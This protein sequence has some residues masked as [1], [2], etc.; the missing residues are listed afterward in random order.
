M[1]DIGVSIL[2][3]WWYIV[4]LITIGGLYSDK[5]P[6][7]C[8]T[9]IISLFSVSV[10]YT[11]T[12]VWKIPLP[13]ESPFQDKFMSVYGF[14]SWFMLSLTVY[15]G[16]IAWEFKTRFVSG[17]AACILF[18][19]AIVLVYCGLH[20]WSD[21][22]GGLCFGLILLFSYYVFLNKTLKLKQQYPIIIGTFLIAGIV[23]ALFLW[24]I[25]IYVNQAL[26]SLFGVLLA[27]TFLHKNLYLNISL[28][29]RIF[30]LIVAVIGI[31]FLDYLFRNLI[32]STYG[33]YEFR[34]SGR[35]ETYFI[36]SLK[37]MIF[38]VWTLL[39]PYLLF[40]GHQIIVNSRA[41]T[42]KP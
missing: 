32:R 16:W 2:M 1:V 30:Y 34:Y 10:G 12:H 38:S 7:F 9:I 3:S 5:F 40:S 8:R 21:I 19:M 35:Q 13:F 25:N 15:W 27:H 31:F 4:I 33:L 24:P 26:G 28:K 20:S 17:V 37:F 29:K 36:Y 42:N 22:L 11:L 23:S 6:V 41:E 18:L 39:G 14:P